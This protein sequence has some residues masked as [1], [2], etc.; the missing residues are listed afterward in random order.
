M[1]L[2]LIFGAIIL[3]GALILPGYFLALAIFPR[4]SDVDLLERLGFSFV[5][6]IA[7]LPLL[8][9]IENQLLGIPINQITSLSSVLILII[10]GIVVWLIRTSRI[11]APEAIYKLFPKVEEKDS[12]AL[13]SWQN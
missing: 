1:S 7:F 12:V 11:P 4:K 6:S 8:M 9:L 13:L 3:L 10:I 2:E 5:F